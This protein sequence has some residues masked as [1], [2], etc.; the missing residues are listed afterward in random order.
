M[1]G[2]V[3]LRERDTRRDRA[4]RFLWRAGTIDEHELV[5]AARLAERDDIRIGLDAVTAEQHVVAIACEDALA[6][7]R[8]VDLDQ[9]SPGRRF[10]AHGDDRLA[11]GAPARPEQRAFV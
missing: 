6:A 10:D 3:D 2:R 4:A 11:V 1:R 5:A 9:L 7:R 8:D